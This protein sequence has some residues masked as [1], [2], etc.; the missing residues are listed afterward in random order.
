MNSLSYFR[1]LEFDGFRSDKSEGL[2]YSRDADGES[3]TIDNV[4][5][6]VRNQIRFNEPDAKLKKIFSMYSVTQENMNSHD[7]RLKD[8]GESAVVILNGNEFLKR[9]E[10]A[11]KE[12]DFSCEFGMVDYIEKKVHK[13][14]MGPFRKYS[15]LLYQSEYRV[16][17]HDRDEGAL[18][19]FSIGDIRDI[20]VLC[21]SD[22]ALNMTLTQR[23][24][25]NQS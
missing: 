8:F 9:I 5:Y 6:T 16:L 20:S 24:S 23:E 19:D 11:A 15:E 4:E 14:S 22:D 2:V 1:E 12:Q 25:P 10:A 18:A 7:A 17:F 3:I 21:S 13:G